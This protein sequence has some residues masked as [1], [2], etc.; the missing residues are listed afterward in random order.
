MS[1]KYSVAQYNLHN[2]VS[3]GVKVASTFIAALASAA[4]TAAQTRSQNSG[5]LMNCATAAFLGLLL[6]SQ[7]SHTVC[8]LQMSLAVSMSTRIAFVCGP[9]TASGAAGLGASRHPPQTSDQ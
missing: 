7:K 3:S 8:P 9:S 5:T 1:H 4:V 6:F 2:S